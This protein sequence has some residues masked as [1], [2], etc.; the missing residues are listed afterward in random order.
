MIVQNIT[1][2][3]VFALSVYGLMKCYQELLI[4]ILKRKAEKRERPWNPVPEEQF[5]SSGVRVEAMAAIMR[6]PTMIAALGVLQSS[7]VVSEPSATSNPEREL[8]RALGRQEALTLIYRLSQPLPKAVDLAE[9]QTYQQT[10]P[11]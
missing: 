4:L 11:E 8:G 5:R 2:A 3:I 10:E 1:T 9:Y 7:L 6:D